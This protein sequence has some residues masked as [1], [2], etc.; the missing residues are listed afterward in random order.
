MRRQ[1]CR[2]SRGVS[3][4][5]P[6]SAPRIPIARQSDQ[7]EALLRIAPEAEIAS[8]RNA[9]HFLYLDQPDAFVQTVISWA[10]RQRKGAT[11]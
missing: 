5:L 7:H 10:M 3:P 2:L 1:L 8:L 4:H 11:A 6:F 9:S